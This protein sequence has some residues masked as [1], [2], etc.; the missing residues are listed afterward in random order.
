MPQGSLLPGLTIAALSF[1]TSPVA[2]RVSAHSFHEEVVTSTVDQSILPR[3]LSLSSIRRYRMFQDGKLR[4]ADNYEDSTQ[5]DLSHAV[6][7][8]PG[9]MSESEA[10]VLGQWFVDHV[11]DEESDAMRLGEWFKD[12]LSLDYDDKPEAAEVVGG[13][14]VDEENEINVVEEEE[15]IDDADKDDQIN[16]QIEDE[17]DNDVDVTLYGDPDCIEPETSPGIFKRRKLLHRRNLGGKSGGKA[18]KSAHAYQLFHSH[19]QP[20][21]E[22]TTTSTV[23][24]GTTSTVSPFTTTTY[25]TV[26]DFWGKSQKSTKSS[27]YSAKSAKSKA[28][29]GSKS[30]EI[31]TE[32]PVAT[33]TPSVRCTKSPTLKPSSNAVATDAPTDIDT[34]DVSNQD[35]LFT[36][37][38]QYLKSISFLTLIRPNQTSQTLPP[39]LGLSSAPTS[40]DVNV[41]ASPVV[42][43]T[44][45]PSGSPVA[46]L[47]PTTASPTEA[48]G[49][50][51]SAPT[52]LPISGTVPPTSLSPISSSPVAGGTLPPTSSS[53]VAGG[54]VP[55]T[56]PSSG[57][58]TLPPTS[59]SPGTLPPTTLVP[60]TPTTVV[61]STSAPSSITGTLP[62]ITST[63]PPTS[64]TPTTPL[65][66]SLSPSTSAPS[67]IG[68]TSAPSTLPPSA[69]VASEIPS[70][71]PSSLVLGTLP[72]TSVDVSSAPSLSN[73]PTAIGLDAPTTIAPTSIPAGATY[74]RSFEQGDFPFVIES[75]DPVWTTESSI[76][77]TLVW[78]L[79]SEMANT[80]IYS[81]KSPV[82]ENDAATPGSANVTITVPDSQP[83]TLYFS[84]NAGVQMPIDAVAWFVDGELRGTVEGMTSFEQQSITVDPGPHVYQFVYAYN[85]GSFPAENLPPNDVLPNRTGTVYIDDVYFIPLAL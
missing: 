33:G 38:T 77:S 18:S 31:S 27:Y 8:A 26:D 71:I 46:V 68:G 1:W 14:E 60:A 63:L 54:T 24:L 7:N 50:T 30:V 21:R 35:C 69:T 12:N 64:A 57:L 81:I 22:A 83:G 79:T 82:L 84:V 3:H 4:R 51:T 59:S 11:P 53:P 39:T 19:I 80:G 76:D 48:G 73:I 15:I 47:A 58:G 20:Y 41:T 25:T 78:T 13:V 9:D 23:S 5:K 28:G 16:D 17:V 36:F 75:T 44:N 62:P 34:N 61:P 67:A 72:P 2:A 70:T 65:G 10:K 74:Y 49:T 6:V 56:A 43:G 42:A 32:I 85:P 52:P 55:P 66:G 29:K 40:N 45:P 37:Y